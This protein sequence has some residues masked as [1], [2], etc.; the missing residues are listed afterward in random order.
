M[1]IPK[2]WSF[3]ELQQ[4]TTINPSDLRAA[5]HQYAFDG[6]AIS[7]RVVIDIIKRTNLSQEDL[8]DL[9]DSAHEG[10]LVQTRQRDTKD[11]F[12]YQDVVDYLSG[13]T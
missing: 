9:L 12:Q 7:S 5:F 11:S 2:N 3:A 8:R 4:Q 10:V 6:W 13:R 1:T